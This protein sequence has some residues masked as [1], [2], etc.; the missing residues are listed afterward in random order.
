MPGGGVSEENTCGALDSPGTLE[1]VRMAIGAG[2]SALGEL[3]ARD[4][5]DVFADVTAA[6]L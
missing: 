4:V 1:A 5:V 3:I 2:D 6:E